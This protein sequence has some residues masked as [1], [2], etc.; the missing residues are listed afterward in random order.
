MAN[1]DGARLGEA[2]HDAYNS[3]DFASADSSISD[4]FTWTV[5]PFGAG[6]S[7]V[8]GYREV[9]ETWSTGFPDSKAETTSL[10]DGGDEG[11]IQFIFRGTHN[12]PL[13]TPNGE[14]P[15]TGRSVEISV[16]NV[17]KASG[18]KVVSGHSY[19]DAATLMRQLGLAP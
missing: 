1:G 4:D 13:Q 6:S 2:I 3:R 16:C 9:M 19:F 11:V 17:W 8:A 15:P 5:V 14:I 12:G 7:G 18:G 10:I